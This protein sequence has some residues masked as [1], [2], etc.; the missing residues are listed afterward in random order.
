MIFGG[1]YVISYIMGLYILHLSVQF[2]TPLGLPDFDS[3]I[4]EEVFGELPTSNKYKNIKIII[5]SYK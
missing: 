5:N 3:E 2:F 4:E 1:F